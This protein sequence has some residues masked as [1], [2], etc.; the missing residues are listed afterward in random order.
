MYNFVIALIV[1]I[2]VYHYLQQSKPQNINIRSNTDNK[3][4]RVTKTN[5][6]SQLKHANMLAS[7]SKKMYLFINSL[8]MSENK[9][10]LM[11]AKLVLEE[12]TQTSD[13]AYTINKGARI[14]LCLENDENTLF[15]IL[16]HEL[17]HV[18][19]KTY[20]HD[21]TFW[22]NFEILV[23]HAVKTGYYRYQNYN[24]IP[25]TYCNQV[26]KYTPYDK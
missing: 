9:E 17:A 2:I 3:I 1:L 11:N 26:I 21:E 22:K 18:I 14:G 24:N 20:G 5:P 7:I 8:S 13:I 23:K 19:T 12:R 16:L 25:T 15:F 6:E 4:Y 10:K